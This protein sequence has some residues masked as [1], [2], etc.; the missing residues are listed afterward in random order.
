M[1]KEKGLPSGKPFFFHLSQY[2]RGMNPFYFKFKSIL[3]VIIIGFL[4]YYGELSLSVCLSL[5][6]MRGVKNLWL[7]DFHRFIKQPFVALLVVF[8]LIKIVTLESNLVV[9]RGLSEVLIPYVIIPLLLS[10][11]GILLI[12]SLQRFRSG[13]KKVRPN[14]H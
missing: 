6:I 4:T 2:D 1:S 3:E 13:K 10:L 7:A 9:A 14:K 8:T 11:E 5:Y 12:S